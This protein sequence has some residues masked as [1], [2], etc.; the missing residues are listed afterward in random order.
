MCTDLLTE[1][2]IRFCEFSMTV[3]RVTVTFWVP[4]KAFYFCWF[5]YVVIPTLKLRLPLGMQLLDHH[6]QY[7]DH[8]YSHL[9]PPN[10][11]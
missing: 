10:I 9:I 5:C 8:K 11:H 3:L 2:I 4:V 6:S 7:Q 1:R